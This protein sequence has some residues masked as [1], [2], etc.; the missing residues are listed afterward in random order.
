MADSFGWEKFF[1]EDG[2]FI[3]T[4]ADAANIRSIQ[5]IYAD[6]VLPYLESVYGEFGPEME[7]GIKISEVIEDIKL[8]I[9]MLGKLLDPTVK[10]E[11]AKKVCKELS[12][13]FPRIDKGIQWVKA[14]AKTDDLLQEYLDKLEKEHGKKLDDVDVAN[15]YIGKKVRG[16][17]PAGKKSFLQNAYQ[18]TKP[19]HMDLK[20]AGLGAATAMLG[21]F[22]GIAEVLAKTAYSTGKGI[23]GHIVESGRKKEMASISKLMGGVNGEQILKYQG[24]MDKGPKA[25]DFFDIKGNR[26][27]GF[28]LGFNTLG[29]DSTESVKSAAS[30]GGTNNQPT[31][32][33]PY[34]FG[35]RARSSRKNFG[36]SLMQMPATAGI[37]ADTLF[38]FFDKD[39]FRSRWTRDIHSVIMK[40][41]DAKGADGS[42]MGGL[43]G[44]IGEF[45]KP[46]LAGIGQ[47]LMKGLPA[48]AIAAAAAVGWSIGTWIR[49]TFPAV[50]KFFE[51]LFTKMFVAW[52][53]LVAGM[54]NMIAGAGDFFNGVFESIGKFGGGIFKT[55]GDIAVAVFKILSNPIGSAMKLG[56]AGF[57]ASTGFLS[58]IFGNKKGKNVKAAESSGKSVE[59]SDKNVN[60]ID[61]VPVVAQTDTSSMDNL[62]EK[63]EK[64]T[65]S[66]DKKDSKKQTTVQQ[67]SDPRSI[68]DVEVES[69]NRGKISMED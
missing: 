33:A 6:G 39:A 28:D 1:S 36:G 40:M 26:P 48:L 21:P 32:P 45:I 62:S 29:K 66:M 54:K 37:S 23:H 47:L 9:Q 43:F 53:N 19:A 12:E 2:I 14:A 22:A 30:N 38:Q 35:N 64:L 67:T 8:A 58:N 44:K 15:K 31:G 63:L 25:S 68:G 27:Q 5:D 4:E 3:F 55:L 49:K 57:K 59:F 42:G 16:F 50:D 41:G 56:E 34:K 24:M 17:K 61:Q 51:S 52:D 46:A 69:L 20:S 10:S 65:K 7:A 13:A 60:K 11:V 18:A